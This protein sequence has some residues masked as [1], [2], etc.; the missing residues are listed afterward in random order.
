[1][2]CGDGESSAVRVLQEGLSER[3]PVQCIVKARVDNGVQNRKFAHRRYSRG[4]ENKTDLDTVFTNRPGVDKR[5]GSRG[6]GPIEAINE[7]L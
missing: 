6:S 5:P 1:M 3:R 7:A 2:V 4:P